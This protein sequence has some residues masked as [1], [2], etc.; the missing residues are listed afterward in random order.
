MDLVK[1]YFVQPVIVEYKN[2]NNLTLR[3]LVYFDLSKKAIIDPFIDGNIFELV[4]NDIDLLQISKKINE[5]I[6]KN[7]EINQDP[8]LILNQQ[9]NINNIIKKIQEDSINEFRKV[10]P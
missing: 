10:Q 1:L 2:E 5:E 9:T 3:K 6:N 8:N 4:K 7:S